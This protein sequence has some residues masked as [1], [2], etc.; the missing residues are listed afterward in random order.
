MKRSRDIIH[1][2][3]RK[4]LRGTKQRPR[5]C[6]FRSNKHIYAQVI[7]DDNATTLVSASTLSKEFLIHAKADKGKEIKA[8]SK[9]AAFIIG[10]LVAQKGKEKG[11]KEIKFDRGGYK[12]HGKIKEFSKGAREGGLVF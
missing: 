5:L 2:R 4:R 11:I 6:I 3:I 7:N 10:K 9:E 12:Y 1:R 8:S